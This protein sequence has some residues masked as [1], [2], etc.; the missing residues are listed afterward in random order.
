MKLLFTGRVVRASRKSLLTPIK[1]LRRNSTQADAS[2][3][4]EAGT[5]FNLPIRHL[6]QGYSN[7]LLL[8]IDIHPE[9]EDSATIRDD[10]FK[11]FLLEK[12]EPNK[13][14]TKG[15]DSGVVICSSPHKL[16]SA[17]NLSPSILKLIDRRLY[18]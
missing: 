11:T 3:E 14:I 5:S 18:A 4:I 13:I 17:S 6:R 9:V 16:D 12:Q 15:A 1:P 2:E 7:R 10:P 8:P